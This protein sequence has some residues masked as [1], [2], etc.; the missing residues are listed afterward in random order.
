MKQYKTVLKVLLIITVFIVVIAALLLVVRKPYNEILVVEAGEKLFSPSYFFKNLDD[1]AE[2]VTPEKE[3]ELNHVGIKHVKVRLNGL[4]YN[5]AF[6]VIDTVS[7]RVIPKDVLE[8]WSGDICE[9][10]DFVT[11]IED[12]TDVK[13]GFVKSPDVFTEGT[14]KVELFA[15]DEGGNRVTFTST[16]TVKKDNESPVITGAK[17]RIVQID[18]TIRY[19]EN[20][21]VTDNREGVIMEIDSSQVDISKEGVY[22]VLYKAY[23]VSGNTTEVTVNYIVVKKTSSHENEEVIK[24]HFQSIYNSFVTDGMSKIEIARAI[25]DYVKSNVSYIPESDKTD[26]MQNA[27]IGITTGKGDCYTYYS[28]CK[29]FFEL[30]GIDNLCVERIN[31]E[32]PHYWNLINCGDGWY[33]FDTCPRSVESLTEIFM[34]T[35]SQLKD[36]STHKN[37]GYY[38]FDESK[39]PKTP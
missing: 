17:D 34:Y 4:T 11:S 30:A 39:Y 23:D 5:V 16:L 26:W 18:S 35:D 15:I 19:R 24:A 28:I 21:T 29:M 8:I 31:H 22:P 9:P 6:D 3:I 33:H 13:I 20:I 1:G 2:Y 38:T 25:Y 36:Y 32:T 12:A 10:K 14:S 37:P 7:P 27:Y